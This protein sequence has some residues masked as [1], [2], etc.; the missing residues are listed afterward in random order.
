MQDPFS[1]MGKM[2]FFVG[3]SIAALGLLLMLAQKSGGNGWFGWFGNLPLDINI[4]KENFRFY[5][6]IGSSIVLSIILSLVF[7]L[8]TKFFR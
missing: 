1:A 4:Q 6:P 2:L 3:A 8:I 5:F 7:G